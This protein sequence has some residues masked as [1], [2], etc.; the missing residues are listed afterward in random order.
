[1]WKPCHSKQSSAVYLQALVLSSVQCLDDSFWKVDA[2]DLKLSNTD[3][4]R[5]TAF[6]A[7][8]SRP[9]TSFETFW[10]YRHGFEDIDAAVRH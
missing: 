9:F 6:L 3:L 2:V 8:S 5:A 10:A 1:M 7:F 4:I